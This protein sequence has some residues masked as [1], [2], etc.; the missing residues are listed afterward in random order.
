MAGGFRFGSA[1]HLGESA[2]GTW[3]LR[4]S[5]NVT[6]NDGV[7]DSWGITVYGH[8][9][10]LSAPTIAAMTPDS[11]SLTV[12]W[13]A[14]AGASGVTA[15]DLRHIETSADET[16]DANWTVTDNAWT[17]AS[18]E[19][20][21]KL[22]GLTNGTQYDVQ[23]R[24]V[25]S[26]VDGPWSLTETGTP[27][28]SSSTAPTVDSV[29]AD[30]GALVVT[31]AAPADT[32]GA[33]STVYDVRYIGSDA[34]DKTDSN[35][36]VEDDASMSGALRYA[37]TG[38]T[39]G[40][41]YDVQVRAVN[42]G[43]DGP[44]SAAGSG[45][46]AD[47]GDTLAA[48]TTVA[49]DTRVSGFIH[50]AG[51]ADHFKFV[52]S[53][54]VDVWIYTTGELDSVGDL[55]D[56]EGL[57]I[58]S[59]DDGRVLPNPQ[60]FFLWRTLAAGTYYVKVV[61]FE[62]SQGP[63]VLRVRTFV[64]TGSRS[65]AAELELGGLASATIDPDSD[66]DYFRLELSEAAD[67]VIRSSGFPDTTGELL[68]SGGQR[69]AF[70]DDG[71]LPGGVRNFLIHT[72]LDRGVYYV[73]VEAI[74][75]AGPYAVYANA[76]T[77]PGSTL[78]AARPLTLG[79]AAGA[80][81]A[82]AG[83]V[84]YFSITVAEPTYVAVRAVSDTV[85]TTGALLDDN[86]MPVTADFTSGPSR[87]S[88]GPDIGFTIYDRL[89]AGT[90]YV[91]VASATSTETGRYT[92]RAVEETAYARLV[93]RCSAISRPSGINDALYGCQWHLTNVGQFS[94][95]ARQDINVEAAWAS[96]ARGTG[97][98]VAVVDDGVH[99]G[100]EDL[101]VN[102]DATQNHDYTGRGDIYDTYE[103]HG[104]A[105]A[106]IIAA[107][108][109][110]IGMRGV[111]PRATIYG[112]NVLLD[113]TDINEAD[114][115]YRNSSTTAISNNSWG[116]L[117]FG[118]VEF[119]HTFWETAVRNGVTTGFDGKGVFYAWAA[120]NG[121]D[122]DDSN[123]DE[124]ANYY[125]VTAVCAVN[126]ADVRSSYSERG[127]NL[128]VCGPS[129]DN[130]RGMQGIA[131]TD[132][133]N[134][135]RDDF[136][137]TSAATPIVSGVAALVRGVNGTLTWRD[138][139]LILAASAR[140]NDAD[141][142]GWEQGALKY[143]SNTERYSF[144]YEYGFGMV[145][146]GAAVAL[147]RSWTNV[148]EFREISAETADIELAIPDA[149]STAT[150]AT[151]SSSVTVDP[152]VGFVEYIQVD[153]NF[154]HPSFR[155]LEVELVS[156][157]GVV[158][159]LAPPNGELGGLPL[160]ATFRFG[161]AKHLGEDA[162]GVWTLRITDHHAGYRGMLKS[163]KL[164]A[165][166][167]GFSPGPPEIATTTP[168][169]GGALSVVWT[170][171]TDIG[172]STVTSY[173]LR[174]IRD[175]APDRSGAHWS[176]LDDVWTSGAL[177]DTLTA[178]EGDLTYVIQVRAVNDAGSGPWSKDESGKPE[179]M[180]P[181]APAISAVSAGDRTLSVVWIAPMD[182]G[183]AAVTSYDLRRIETSADETVDANWTVVDRVWRSGPLRYAATGLTNGTEYDLQVRAVNSAGDGA[184]SATVTGTPRQADVP[185]T[186]SWEQ[187]VSSV[188]ES[189]G[190]VTLRAVA[191][192]TANTAPAADFSFDA[193]VATA[194]GS[195]AQP[196]DYT[197]LSTSVT[198]VA[199]DFSQAEVNGAQRYRAVKEFVL[200]IADDALD[201]PDET[202]T[203]TLA[204]TTPGLPHL[205]GGP[206][207]ATVTITDDDH[208]P[209]TIAWERAASTV[210][211]GA[212]TVTLNAVVV[213]TID[214]VPDSGFSFDVS[215][216]T[217]QG[218]AV[219]TDDY[220]RLYKTVTFARSAFRRSTVDGQRRYRAV[221]QIRVTIVDDILDEPDESFSI[222][223]AYANPGLPHLQGGPSTASVTI[224]DND[225]VP[226]TIA[227]EE[228][229]FTVDEDVGTVTLRAVAVTTKDKMPETGFSFGVS[230]STAEGGAAQTE[231]YGRLNVTESFSLRD[232]QR[233]TVNGQQ[234]YRAVRD[235]T[236]RIVDDTDD[237]S[238]R[239]L[240]RKRG[241]LEPRS[242]VP[243]G[244]AGCR[245]DK[246][247]RQRPRARGP[248]LGSDHVNRG[249]G[250]RRHPS[251]RCR[252]DERQDA[253]DRLLLRRHRV[254]RQR[255]RAAAG[256]LHS[257]FRNRD[258]QPERLQPDDCQRT[259]ALPGGEGFH[260][261][262]RERQRSRSQRVLQGERGV[263]EPRTAAPHRGRRD[264][265]DN[266]D[267]R[268]I[269]DRGLVPAGARI[270][271]SGL[272]GRR[273]DLRLHSLELRPRHF[274]EHG[275]RHHARSGSEL[276]CGDL[277]GGMHPLRANA[278]RR[279]HLPCRDSPGQRNGIRHRRGAGRFDDL[280]GHYHH[281]C[282]ER[283]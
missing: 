143:G 265:D 148:P 241:V 131:T 281:V 60:N 86:G 181:T 189:A 191:V 166:G 163:W 187:A 168:S 242:T 234:R 213:T 8:S 179:T 226:V 275:R 104:T 277:H 272:S 206:S 130:A 273:A 169:G 211:E 158:S 121:G 231:D 69:I 30:D 167:H 180:A 174:Y 54:Q 200:A 217:A 83:D 48:A 1:R 15:Y 128:W 202:F 70:N 208:V 14:P 199:S 160:E 76:V 107:R 157:T 250:E 195:A 129:S 95:G 20:S 237:E 108:D 182:T 246:H 85:T 31:W 106:G 43:V 55:L 65:D 27:A 90:Y 170:A 6:G 12:A 79:V 41:G 59:N 77:E 72:S 24:A 219:E 119:T 97:I 134:R 212:G 99:H 152:Y 102:V 258:L 38:L 100:H 18:G 147:A 124:F 186:L 16:V 5:D 45:T 114:A 44:W 118:A 50:S 125:A 146:A 259:A 89:D 32:G 57:S 203:A 279:G 280:R 184:W 172:G 178:L 53:R 29:R 176:V 116:P 240:H 133:G 94:R 247:H 154:D 222:T 224:T 245:G 101:S 221:G 127:S 235:I 236:V 144:N 123:L 52:L 37:V 283:Q 156:P 61:G 233:A 153:A 88:F 249:G 227:F 42:D 35:W 262:R 105:V 4:V 232:F 190:T 56:S 40:V 220:T 261:V 161:S 110:G 51:D 103:T 270:D 223:L 98:T 177:T 171:P 207:T 185:V 140:K 210:D 49:P 229:A 2:A 173:D 26:G 21:Y 19:L 269:D 214:K 194:D 13:T 73:R 117:D 197:E 81:I 80:S 267:R 244:R 28:A 145:D 193:T 46:P 25:A 196:A 263:L 139:K 252:D 63:Y 183:G 136:G 218:V 205:R 268:L 155:D 159:T 138:V 112:Y 230:V 228:T 239:G 58:D 238:G 254:D 33:T 120:G 225:H 192:T 111:A 209:V 274:D 22:E 165:Y 3:T 68:D 282:R 84:D 96:G 132:N 243:P 188:D 257:A 10:G 66:V 75:G 175:D 9:A 164:T 17:S 78:A 109:N 23:V 251:R 149:G 276:R 36:S 260:R 64:D 135:Y 87:T 93:N 62:A 162:A 141:D 278:G 248:R 115:M 204:Y 255:Q 91:K 39:N 92:I 7:L 47:H 142:S 113:S 201:E 137:G 264:R 198:L 216:S 215:V 122:D 151:V 253:G 126:H 71:Y 256:G 67:V 150:G 11:G 82:P 271:V 34:T 74:I 266:G